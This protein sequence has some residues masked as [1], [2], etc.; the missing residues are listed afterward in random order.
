MEYFHE[1][2]SASIIPVYHR[3]NEKKTYVA[4]CIWSAVI[5]ISVLKYSSSSKNTDYNEGRESMKKV[6]IMRR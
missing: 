5:K 6:N 4:D 1:R 2:L 3:T